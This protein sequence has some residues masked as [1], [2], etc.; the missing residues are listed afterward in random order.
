MESTDVRIVVSGVPNL[1]FGLQKV[2]I[3]IP[4]YNEEYYLPA[5]LE[6]LSVLD[7][8][9]ELIE[10]IVVDNGSTDKTI[11]IA[12][13]FGATVFVNS[14]KN[15]SGLRNLGASKSTGT[16]LAFVDADCVVEKC[17]LRKAAIYF[18]DYYVAAWGCPPIIPENSSWVQK[19]WFFVRQKR[20]Q[21]EEVAWLETMNLFVRK[22]QFIKIGCFCESLVTCED[23]DISY[24]IAEFGK[25]IADNRIVVTHFGE[26]ATLKQ[27]LKKEIW[28]G[29][30]NFD[31]VKKH[32]LFRK[33]IPSLI[34]PL[35]FGLILPVSLV[36]YLVKLTSIF[37]ITLFFIYTMPI[38][39]AVLKVFKT[40]K[41]VSIINLIRL[42]ILVQIYFFARTVAVLKRR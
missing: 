26:A 41:D 11:K 7:Y 10:I 20:D 38:A 39:I 28:R 8:P 16:V 9:D 33:E 42:S 13:A 6:S 31:G 21:K 2:S 34:I 19:T 5:C 3:I 37:G 1:N 30:S 36:M 17:W 15:I 18:D 24:R 25:I 23:V 29:K 12:Q 40:K 4:T 22:K 32:G 14:T 35:Y 27:F